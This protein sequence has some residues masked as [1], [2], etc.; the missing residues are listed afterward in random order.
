M[1]EV[2]PIKDIKGKKINIG[3][4]VRITDFYGVYDA[5]VEFRDG[6]FTINPFKAKQVKNSKGWLEGLEKTFPG[7]NKTHDQIES[8]GFLV[9]WG[10][11]FAEPLMRSGTKFKKLK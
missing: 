5:P 4:I 7:E 9:H 10:E 11:T 2:E 1:I 3:D 8:Y 6:M